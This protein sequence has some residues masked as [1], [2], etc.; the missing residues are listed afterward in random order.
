M[1]LSDSDSNGLK[2]KQLPLTSKLFTNTIVLTKSGWWL[3]NKK[4]KVCKKTTLRR[5]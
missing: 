4:N 2:D 5:T 1:T 3:F